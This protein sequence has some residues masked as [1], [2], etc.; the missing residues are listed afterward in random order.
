M[1][2]GAVA[3]GIRPPSREG[4]AWLALKPTDRSEACGPPLVGAD[5]DGGARF[6]VELPTNGCGHNA[7]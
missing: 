5:H 4:W 3:E 1:Y 6:V 2:V 7:E